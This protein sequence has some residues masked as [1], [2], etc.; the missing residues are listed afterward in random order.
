M[1]LFFLNSVDTGHSTETAIG[2]W[3]EKFMFWS[4]I[5]KCNVKLT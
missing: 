3:S 1:L 2:K 4:K 5:S